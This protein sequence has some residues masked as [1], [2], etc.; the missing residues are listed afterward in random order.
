MYMILST[1]VLFIFLSIFFYEYGDFT[2]TNEIDILNARQVHFSIVLVLTI[3]Y[4]HLWWFGGKYVNQVKP[5]LCLFLSLDFD[6][7]WFR[8]TQVISIC[9][10]PSMLSVEES[11]SN[12]QT[13][14]DIQVTKWTVC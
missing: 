5:V 12:N 13:E 10:L 2:L 14:Y 7:V 11:S 1:L 9:C 4:L 3:H 8:L 6:F